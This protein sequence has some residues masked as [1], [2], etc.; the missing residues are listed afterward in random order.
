MTE[1]QHEHPWYMAVFVW[2]GVL[3]ILEVGV[4]YL[5]LDRF[6]MIGILSILA[7]AKAGLVALY[8]M[9]LKFETRRLILF[10]STPV[11]CV[12]LLVF[13]VGIDALRIIP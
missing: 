1:A 8:F 3:T 13:V 10:V 7:V 5:S 2:L 9:H 12:M 11:I 4:T 6:V